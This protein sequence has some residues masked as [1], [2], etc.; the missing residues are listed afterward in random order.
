MP[1]VHYQRW[2]VFTPQVF[3]GNQLAVILDADSLDT[4]AM[5]R[6]A[7]EFALPETAFARSDCDSTARYRLRIFTPQNELPMAG[8]PTIGAAFALARAGRVAPGT[9]N[10]VLELGVG[11]TEIGLRWSASELSEAWMAQRYPQFGPACSD[12]ALLAG[13]L[14]LPASDIAG[15]ETPARILSSGV[16]LLFI[17]LRTRA[18]VDRAVL[19]RQELQALC[20]DLHV[21][22]CPVYLFSVEQADDD[23]TVYSRMFAPVFGIT[24]D[25][26]TGGASGPLGA[27]LARYCPDAVPASGAVL[28]LQGVRMGRPS[29]IFISL[30]QIAAAVPR[31][32]IG[33]EAVFVGEGTL[34]Y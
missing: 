14:T 33:G 34:R 22:E 4:D 16:S 15:A 28:N 5:Q 11:P 24:E 7:N 2:D 27:Y 9:T 13:I 25:P 18:A 32:E 19:N 8:H 6:I 26:A 17:P 3:A 10:I 20:T 23:A 1:E 30:S 31:L 21:D 29:R 12:A